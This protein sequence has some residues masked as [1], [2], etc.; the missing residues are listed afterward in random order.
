MTGPDVHS[1]LNNLQKHLNDKTMESNVYYEL[2][3]LFLYQTNFPLVRHFSE[4]GIRK[5][6]EHQQLQ[7]EMRGV[8]YCGVS[9]ELQHD[10]QAALK[11]FQSL[12]E[13]ARECENNY[14]LLLC[15]TEIANLYYHFRSF[16]QAYQYC[17]ESL[18]NL[19]TVEDVDFETGISYRIIR[20]NILTHHHRAHPLTTLKSETKMNRPWWQ[21]LL[22]NNLAVIKF[23]LHQPRDAEA[24][25]QQSSQLFHSSGED[26]SECLYNIGVIFEDSGQH[27]QALDYYTRALDNARL[28]EHSFSM[29]LSALRIG[30]LKIFL[31]QSDA[32]PFIINEVVPLK[33]ALHSEA[34]H[35]NYLDLI[36]EEYQR[37]TDLLL[38]ENHELRKCLSMSRTSEEKFFQM[39]HHSGESIF[40]VC[41]WVLAYINPKFTEISGYSEDE[42]IGTPL[43]KL[44]H[45]EHQ[46]ILAEKYIE[47]SQGTTAK[48]MCT[49][50]LIRKC[51][52]TLWIQVKIMPFEWDGRSA[53]INYANDN[54]ESHHFEED[55]RR[56]QKLDSLGILAGGIAHDFNNLLTA[57]LGNVSI[58]KRYTEGNDKLSRLLNQAENATHRARSLTNQLLTFSKGGTPVTR[59]IS[60]VSLIKTI[61]ESVSRYSS[62]ICEY[63]IPDDLW[64]VEVD[65]EQIYQVFDNIIRNATEAMPD[66]GRVEITAENIHSGSLPFMGESETR[67]VKIS[68]RDQGKGIPAQDKDRV[69]DPYFTTKPQRSGLGLTTSYSIIKRHRGHIGLQSEMGTGS[70]FYFYLPAGENASAQLLPNT[71]VITPET[72]RILVMDDEEIVR[73]AV[74]SMLDEFGFQTISVSDGSEA[75]SVYSEAIHSGERFDLVIMDLT[76]PGGMGGAEAIQRLRKIDPNIRAIVSSGYSDHPVISNY[77]HYGFVGCLNKPYKIET[78]YHLIQNILIQHPPC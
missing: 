73:L 48:Q 58:A 47:C 20:R 33:N 13:T 77:K 36:M 64:M 57:I 51:G 22:L 45:P 18:E 24:D 60:I 25:L 35:P 11:T 78:L 39:I 2:A 74:C 27:H 59:S 56:T 72:I 71:Q 5:S 10:D 43:M 49:L 63:S 66:G 34:E 21:A 54:M 32:I 61:S 62:I 53:I 41:D 76:I 67:F 16:D 28:N 55:I 17:L 15:R 29:V 42:L 68:I 40:I 52:E 30:Y 23:A 6:K 14:F 65:E 69:F 1:F 70:T 8:Y 4:H 19:P 12:Y 44:I 37:I 31:D 9:F 38:L 26:I 3:E 7:D 75:I 50:R 46:R